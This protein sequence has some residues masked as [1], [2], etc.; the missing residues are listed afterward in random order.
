MFGNW[1]GLH[2]PWLTATQPFAQ[3]G[4]SL[5]SDSAARGAAASVSSS[6]RTNSRI[7]LFALRP[8]RG[9]AAWLSTALLA[10]VIQRY[11]R[12]YAALNR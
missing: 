8:V 5:H 6:A 10:D 3:P 7:A 11:F 9:N 1:L 2:T 12:A 4:V